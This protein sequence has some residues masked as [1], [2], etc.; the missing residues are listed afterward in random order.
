MQVK[1]IIPSAMKEIT[2]EVSAFRDFDSA[3]VYSKLL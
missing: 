1:R 3:H 2:I